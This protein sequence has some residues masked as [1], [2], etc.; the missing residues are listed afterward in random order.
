[1]ASAQK[2]LEQKEYRDF[3]VIDLVADS[4]VNRNTFY[5]H[6]R[7]MEALVVE[8]A[9]KGIDRCFASCKGNAAEK[10]HSLIDAVLKKRVSIMHVY[11]SA[12]RTDF[13]LGLDAACEYLAAKLYAAHDELQNKTEYE[14]ACWF[15]MVKGCS[16][17]LFCDWLS[18]GLDDD[19]REKLCT[20]YDELLSNKE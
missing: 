17:G 19:S 8:L 2:M 1:M 9:K 5:Y 7:D 16:Y 18:K 15:L 14:K 3:T 11:S 13:D 4:G 12:Y 20:I 6:F 10:M